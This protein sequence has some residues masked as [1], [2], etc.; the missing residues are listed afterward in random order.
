[1]PLAVCTTLADPDAAHRLARSAVEARLAACV[2]IEEIEAVYR[3]AGEV[4]DETGYRLLF[5]TAEA[6]YDALAAH[7]LDNH[8]H[9]EPALWALPLTMGSARYLRWI[10]AE[11]SGA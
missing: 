10:D 4:K 11:S 8:P 5:K 2:H 1:M 3:W 9:E 6:R 7:I